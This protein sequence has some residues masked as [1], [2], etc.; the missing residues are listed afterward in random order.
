MTE[1]ENKATNEEVVSRIIKTMLLELFGQRHEFDNFRINVASPIDDFDPIRNIYVY[2]DFNQ[3]SERFAIRYHKLHPIEDQLGIIARRT[4][5]EAGRLLWL[6]RSPF[7]KEIERSGNIL[8]EHPEFDMLSALVLEE[9]ER[10]ARINAYYEKPASI[11]GH[12]LRDIRASLESGF[13]TWY[14]DKRKQYR[15]EWGRRKEDDKV[16]F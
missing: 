3:H 16:N 11:V 2:F 13:T 5:Q 1:Q 14:K 8:L 6:H 9:M 12:V 4:E 15:K 7:R 10:S